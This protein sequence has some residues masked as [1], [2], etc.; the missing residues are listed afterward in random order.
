MQQHVITYFVFTHTLDPWGPK[1][2]TTFFLKLV[3]LHIKLM[4][5]EHR[6]S[7][8]SV[9]T[10][11]LDPWGGVKGSKNIFTK[12]SNVAYQIKGDGT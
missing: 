3:M 2:K 9:L 5:M 12:G 6:A 8:N 11:T 10:H 1:V 4:G 7:T